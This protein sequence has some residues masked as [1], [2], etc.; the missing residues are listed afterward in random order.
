MKQTS[1]ADALLEYNNLKSLKSAGIRS[2]V[3]AMDHFEGQCVREK[4]DTGTVE[5]MVRLCLSFYSLFEREKDT[6][7]PWCQFFV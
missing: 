2:V 6:G 1:V 5:F 7:E 4:G 3:D